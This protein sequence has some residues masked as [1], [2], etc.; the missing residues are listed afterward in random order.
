MNYIIIDT[1][2]T[3]L[4]D[5]K[6]GTWPKIISIAV[7]HTAITENDEMEIYSEDEYYILDWVEELSDETS[8]F[9]N[10]DKDTV[11]KRGINFEIVK[12][13][14]YKLIKE[15]GG[16]ENLTF[17]A[18]NVRFDY[19]VLKTCGLDLSSY[20]W[21][22]TMKNGQL[23]LNQSKYPKL[24]EL[25]KFYNICIDDDKLHGALYDTQICA[26]VL[27][28]IKTNNFNTCVKDVRLLELRNRSVEIYLE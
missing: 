11:R 20:K 1:E 6:T 19:N 2:T 24:S 10:L 26:N 23:C 4:P 12:N 27:Y 16:Y 7:L 17:V 5:R 14:I 18:H 25:A 21:F 15:C 8:K 13:K 3:G 22:C 9:L 28:C